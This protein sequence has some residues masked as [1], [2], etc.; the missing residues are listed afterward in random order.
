MASLILTAAAMNTSGNEPERNPPTDWVA[1]DVLAV[2]SEINETFVR[3]LA[4]RAV[5]T[6]ETRTDFIG[7]L[8][9][10]LC[11]SDAPTKAAHAPVLL[12]DIGFHDPDWWTVLAREPSRMAALGR[13]PF[14]RED[15]V[16]LSRA[17]LMLAWHLSRAD[18]ASC[19]ILLGLS[20]PVARIV[21]TLRPKQIDQIAESHYARLR[22]RWEDRPSV[23][24]QLLSGTETDQA[25]M[26]TFAIRA[27]ELSWASARH[28]A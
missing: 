12:L 1:R 22:P 16:E 2:L 14:P 21:G 9:E 10:L 11:R 23:W 18:L 27:L 15:A 24:Q 28:T 26:R 3:L 13:S 4:D 8:R 25:S 17:T 5:L 19:L 6:D 20:L 7:A